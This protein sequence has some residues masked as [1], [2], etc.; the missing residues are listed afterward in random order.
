LKGGVAADHPV[1]LGYFVSTKV[2]DMNETLKE[3]LKISPEKIEELKMA[4]AVLMKE[5]RELEL[6]YG[7]HVDLW[8]RNIWKD[9]CKAGNCRGSGDGNVVINDTR[10]VSM[11]YCEVRPVYNQPPHEKMV[12]YYSEASSS[13]ERLGEVEIGVSNL[14]A[15]FDLPN[16]PLYKAGELYKAIMNS[17]EVLKGM[18]KI[19]QSNIESVSKLKTDSQCSKIYD[20]NGYRPLDWEKTRTYFGL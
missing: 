13:G 16:T 5:E 7:V 1:Q 20:G 17:P 2:A 14:H 8:G 6:E 4:Q 19:I 15:L 9:I 12:M 18:A 3:I 11:P 10:D